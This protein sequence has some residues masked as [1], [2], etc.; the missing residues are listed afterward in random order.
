MKFMGAPEEIGEMFLFMCSFACEFM[1]A[2]TV[3]INEG[4]V[5]R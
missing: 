4:G 3:D 2:H 5:F 1:T